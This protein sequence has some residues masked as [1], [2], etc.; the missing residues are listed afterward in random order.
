ME[1]GGVNY[2]DGI[3][4]C[5]QGSSTQPSGLFTMQASPP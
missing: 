2:K 4:F 3:L 5:A 1:N